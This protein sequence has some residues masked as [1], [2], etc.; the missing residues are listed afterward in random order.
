MKGKLHIRNEHLIVDI[1]K[2]WSKN[3]IKLV[4]AEKIQSFGI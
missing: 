2:R 1:P 4:D 3:W